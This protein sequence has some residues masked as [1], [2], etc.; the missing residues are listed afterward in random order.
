MGFDCEFPYKGKENYVLTR[1]NDLA[2]D[3]N[4]TYINTDPIEFIKGLKSE[5]GGVIWVVGG[6]QV[7]TLLLSNGLIDEIRVFIMPVIIDD[8]IELFSENQVFVDLELSKNK[9]YDNGVVELVYKV[10]S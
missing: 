3:E 7:N 5:S 4:V 10:K 9:V 1:R 2:S 6:G 8:G